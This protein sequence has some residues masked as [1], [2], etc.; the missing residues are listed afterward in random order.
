M[1]QTF[2]GD[3]LWHVHFSHGLWGNHPLVLVAYN[4]TNEYLSKTP[5][6]IQ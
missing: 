6:H 1:R 2:N 3:L 5:I 4:I